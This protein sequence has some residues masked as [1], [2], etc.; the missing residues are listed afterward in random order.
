MKNTY[1]SFLII[2]LMLSS[3]KKAPLTPPTTGTIKH[4]PAYIAPAFQPGMP[5]S[6]TEFN[7]Y[8]LDHPENSEKQYFRIDFRY[9]DSAVVLVSPRSIDSIALGWP[10]SQRTMK[11]SSGAEFIL[12]GLSYVRIS[13]GAFQQ[14]AYNQ[15]SPQHAWLGVMKQTL[16]GAGLPDGELL[17]SS[18]NLQLFFLSSRLATAIS[19][20]DPQGVPTYQLYDM[21]SLFGDAFAAYDWRDV[22]QFIYFRSLSQFYFFDFKNWRYFTIGKFDGLAGPYIG[23]PAKSLDRFVKWPEGWGRKL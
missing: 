19:A 18:G 7:I 3:C 17:W 12:D 10:A 20:R 21:A 2:G 1:F 23:H 22:S 8:D 6:L 15:N 13:G 5:F 14:V 11:W 16:G 9:T 4:T